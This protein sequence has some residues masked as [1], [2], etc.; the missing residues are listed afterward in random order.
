MHVLSVSIVHPFA[1]VEG[2][3]VLRLPSMHLIDRV[4]NSNALGSWKYISGSS[5]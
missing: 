3:K 2:L 4:L 5:I 1:L